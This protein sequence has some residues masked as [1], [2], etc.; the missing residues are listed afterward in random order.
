MTNS[1]KADILKQFKK[2]FDQHVNFFK[3]DFCHD[4]VAVLNNPTDQYLYFLRDTGSWIIRITP[5]ESLIDVGDIDVPMIQQIIRDNPHRY[6]WDGN[7][8]TEI[9]K[10]LIWEKMKKH[11]IAIS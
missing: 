5:T 4:A 10:D 11:E 6:F 7:T 1:Q 2:C 8:M 3:D 9:S